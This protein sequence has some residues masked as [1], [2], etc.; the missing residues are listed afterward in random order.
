LVLEPS[1]SHN[2]RVTADAERETDGA[3]AGGPDGGGRLALR[4]AVTTSAWTLLSRGLGFV[5]DALLTSHFGVGPLTGAFAIAWVVPNLFRRLLGEGAVGAA[6]Q[7]ALARARV[8]HGED[9][10]RT[11]YAR[12]H[13]FLLLMLV[14]AALA[15]EG[16][17]LVLL[18]RADPADRMALEFAAILVPYMVPICLTALMAAPQQMR[19]RYALPAMAPLVLNG[20]LIAALVG[21][22]VFGRDL[23]GVVA[24]RWICLTILIAGGCQWLL[25]LPGVRAS[26]Y[27]LAPVLHAGDGSVRR[28]MKGFAPALLGLAAVQLNFALDQL[29][30]RLLVDDSA[31]TYTYL[32]NR[33]LQLPL[34][35]VAMAAATG[36]LPLF[37]R[38]AAERRRRE[39]D[40]VLE[41]TCETTLLLTVAAAAGLYALARP[42]VQVLFEHGNFTA[43]DTAML[44]S[45]LRGYLWCLPAA[46]MASILTRA[47]QSHGDLRGPALAAVA[48]I[49]INL[50]LDLLLLPRFGV[51]GAGYATAAALSVQAL[52]LGVGL[53]GLEIGAPL[54]LVRLPRILAPGL[55]AGAVGGLAGHLLG[56]AAGTVAGLTL[57]VSSGV[58]FA[59]VL[60]AVL[61]PEDFRDLRNHLRRR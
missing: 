30:V 40:G 53:R 52:L 26:G 4:G 45:T 44:T 33:L 29:L 2:R 36:T 37:A 6:I 23:D 43:E 57:A 8:E 48:G 15:T 19:G 50:V 56:D 13:G 24:M 51:V 58:A 11:L 28:T 59:V 17:I 27:P 1:G 9:A 49:P 25:Q 55:A 34:A 10:A 12:F 20:A 47:R 41:R 22:E 16:V 32:A 46:S 60:T 7:P 5:R 42:V 3:A 39:F 54:R 14:G 35:L 21:L 38:L 31:N 18:L 61:L